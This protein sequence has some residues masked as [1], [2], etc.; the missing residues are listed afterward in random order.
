MGEPV[1][2]AA[3]DEEVDLP[4]GGGGGVLQG[5]LDFVEAEVDDRGDGRGGEG[6]EDDLFIEAVELRGVKRRK[7]EG[8]RQCQ[9]FACFRREER[10]KR[11][12]S[13]GYI[14]ATRCNTSCFANSVT[15]PSSRVAPFSA[16]MSLPMLLVRMMVVFFARRGRSAVA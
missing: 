4:L 10:E 13:G 12:N 11:T 6:V 2:R 16:R 1:P 5:V 7:R 8:E 9:S 15:V 14:D 3:F